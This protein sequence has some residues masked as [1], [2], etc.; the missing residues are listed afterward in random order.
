MQKFVENPTKISSKVPCHRVDLTQTAFCVSELR[1]EF[2][3]V[4]T[5]QE[6]SLFIL[7]TLQ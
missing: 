6:L 7:L 3:Y 2:T 1:T 5:V 4:T